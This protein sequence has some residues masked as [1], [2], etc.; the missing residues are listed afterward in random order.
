MG[1]EARMVTYPREPH[2]I[3][4]VEHQLDIQ[5]RVLAWYDTHL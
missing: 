3:G 1:K 5:R 4:E 2:R